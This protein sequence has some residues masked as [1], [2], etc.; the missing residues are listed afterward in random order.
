MPIQKRKIQKKIIGRKVNEQRLPLNRK[1]ERVKVKSVI[2]GSPRPDID[3]R[4]T[5]FGF[6][7]LQ[8]QPGFYSQPK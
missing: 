5:V 2:R 4:D 1:H 7:W 8:L 6:N 3:K